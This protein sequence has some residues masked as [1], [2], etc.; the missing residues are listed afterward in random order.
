V[1]FDRVLALVGAR[2]LG[3]KELQTTSDRYAGTTSAA[4]FVVLA[5]A[6]VYVLPRG[7]RK[8]FR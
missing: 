4:A 5:S 7:L 2:T 3:Y 6:Q 8:Q 1:F